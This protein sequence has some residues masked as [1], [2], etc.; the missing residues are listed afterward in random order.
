MIYVP[1]V[2]YGVKNNNFLLYMPHVVSL[3]KRTFKVH[4]VHNKIRP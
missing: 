1:C 2:P 3:S 4:M